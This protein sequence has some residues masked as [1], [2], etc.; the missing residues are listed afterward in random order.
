MHYEP[1]PKNIEQDIERIATQQHISTNEALLKVVET[2]LDQL[3]LR[4]VPPR[5]ANQIDIVA[6]AIRKA[7]SVRESRQKELLALGKENKNAAKLI[8]FLKDEP[9][10]VDAIR[11][12]TRDHRRAINQ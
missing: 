8:G 3:R 1:L 6:D 5:K 12:A 2:G 9:E 10:I 11:E 7:E 4:S